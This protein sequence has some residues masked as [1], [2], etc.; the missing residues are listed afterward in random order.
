MEGEFACI[1]T[2]TVLKKLITYHDPGPLIIPKGKGFGPDE[3]ITLP[4]WLSEE[5]INYYARKYE[6][7]GFTGGF[8]YY[9]ALDL[10]WELTAP[11]T[12]AQVQVPVKF[13]IGDQ[14]MVYNAPGVKLFIHGGLMK[15]YMRLTNIFTTSSKNSNL[16]CW[17]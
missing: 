11:W 13:I 7:R 15:K 17:C 8:N 2:A 3:P 1:G 5:D 14:D 6:Q 16:F 12:G 4:S 9:R 10:N